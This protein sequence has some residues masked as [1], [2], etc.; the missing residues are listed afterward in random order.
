MLGHEH[1][2]LDLRRERRRHC[3]RRRRDH[4]LRQVRQGLALGRWLL[5]DAGQ[6]SGAKGL[7]RP[8]QLR[9][10]GSRHHVH[11]RAQESILRGA[12]SRAGEG[13]VRERS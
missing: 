9:A 12:H 1:A 8:L 7:D 6:D 4:V 11:E 3:A 5:N 13:R 10:T 2:S